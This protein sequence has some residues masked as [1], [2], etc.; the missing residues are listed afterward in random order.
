MSEYLSFRLPE[1]FLADYQERTPD[2]GFP[3]GGGNSLAELTF[4]SKYSRLKE[5]GTKERWWEVCRRC[6]EGYYLS[7]IHI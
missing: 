7:L 5:D 6:I 3:I 1:D 4:Y 2:W